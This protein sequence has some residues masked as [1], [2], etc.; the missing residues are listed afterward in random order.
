MIDMTIADQLT[1]HR[2]NHL[3]LQYIYRVYY[4]IAK[5]KL[6]STISAVILNLRLEGMTTNMALSNFKKKLPVRVLLTNN[7]QLIYSMIIFNV[8]G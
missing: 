4:K 2:L 5:I 3:N 1:R 7:L 6:F 8:E